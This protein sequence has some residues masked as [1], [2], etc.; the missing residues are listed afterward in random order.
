M[1]PAFS[2]RKQAASFALLLLF[3]LGAPWLA[4]KRL[5]P[6]REQAYASMGWTW[7]PYPWVKKQIF[8]ETNDIDIA[9]MGSS[10]INC[11][12]DTPYVQERLNERLGRKTAVRS[13]CWAGAGFDALFITAKDLLEHRRVKTL[14]F[15]DESHFIYPGTGAKN[16]YRFGDDAASLSGLQFRFKAYYYFAA[17]VG[18]PRNLLELLTP[19]LPEEKNRSVLSYYELIWHAD[20]PENRLGA[21]FAR[22]GFRTVGFP[23]DDKVDTFVPYFPKTSVTPSDLCIYTPATA[24]NFAFSDR[25]L[26]VWQ[27]YFLTQF[28]LEAKN[29][30]CQLVLLHVPLLQ[31][32]ASFKIT[33]SAYW[34]NVLRTDVAMMGIPTATLLDGMSEKD[35]KRLF[36]SDEHM[37]QNGMEYF[38]PLIIPALFQLYESKSDH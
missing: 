20:N 23:G 36:L 38:T 34:P 7:G 30:G 26:P 14:V 11:A 2:S 35:I 33:E 25:P 17:M 6:P 31:E 16:W 5:L 21:V 13:I 29:H 9:F 8:D 28:A 32:K 19:N 10:R 1:A 37:N 18:M 12:I 22:V 27:T 24:S 15:C 3:L 4:G